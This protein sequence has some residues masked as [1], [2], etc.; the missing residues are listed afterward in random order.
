MNLPVDFLKTFVRA[1]DLKSFT[2]AGQDVGRTQ[3][4]VS[5]QM[6]RL[7]EQAGRALFDRS[8]RELALTPAGESL[9]PYARRMVK[10]HDE[11]VSALKEP[12]MTGKVRLGVLD[13][14]APFYL[15][16]VLENFGADHPRVQVEVR[17]DC[18][19]TLVRMLQ[20]GEL[21][22][23]VHSGES[24]GPYGRVVD[25]DPLVWVSSAR[26][27]A[28]EKDPLPLAVFDKKCRF[29]QWALDSLEQAGRACRICYTSPSVTGVLA[30]VEAGLA[31]APLG[32]SS[33]P[34]GALVLGPGQGFPPLPVT[35]IILALACA[36]PSRPVLRLAEA[37]RSGLVQGTARKRSRWLGFAGRTI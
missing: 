30:A 18:S 25:R 36:E 11:A 3:S 22:L 9:L 8:G 24:P 31:V 26:H 28:H 6:K 20:S 16:P 13:D 35:S 17:C 19:R 21:D 2:L 10:L 32:L 1:V 15:P 27:A 29:R 12:D 34:D 4:A 37:V 7:E 5:Q 33:V 23:A 14:Y